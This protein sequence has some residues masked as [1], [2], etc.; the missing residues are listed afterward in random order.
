MNL[1]VVAFLAIKKSA[2]IWV[3]QV[4]LKWRAICWEARRNQ[5][6]LKRGFWEKNMKI[7]HLSLY[8]HLYFNYRKSN[9]MTTLEEK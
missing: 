5:G 1:Y 7:S 4:S 3:N 9:T 6:D 8:P 2:D